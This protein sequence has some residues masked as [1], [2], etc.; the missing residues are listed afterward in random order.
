LDHSAIV[1]HRLVALYGSVEQVTVVGQAERA[2]QAMVLM[3]AHP[4]DLVITFRCQTA[5]ASPGSKSLSGSSPRRS[6]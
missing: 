5:T 6:S 2:A 4:A 3:S 1:R